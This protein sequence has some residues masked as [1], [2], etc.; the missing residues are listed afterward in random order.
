M[1]CKEWPRYIAT[2]NHFHGNPAS[3]LL[4]TGN[5]REVRGQY[6]FKREGLMVT[7]QL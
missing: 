4:I 2:C 7:S 3:H 6:V 5:Q 1:D